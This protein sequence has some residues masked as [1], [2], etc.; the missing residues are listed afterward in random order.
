M[1]EIKQTNFWS[2]ILNDE[3]S[4]L[5]TGFWHSENMEIVGKALKQVVNNQ[6][7]N[8]CSYAVAN[9][10][11][12]L[13]QNGTDIYG[14]G[15][16]N[17][18]NHDV[19]IW[20]KTNS[21]SGNWGIA[22]NGTVAGTTFASDNPLFAVLNGVIFF[23]AGNGKVGKY[24]I[25]TNTM[26][27]TWKTGASMKG[28]TI[29]QGKIYGWIGQDIYVIDPVA[30]TLTNMKAV[31]TEQVIV[32]LVPYGSL[33]MVVCTS[34]VTLSRA[35]LWDGVST[36]S[37]VEILDVGQGLV[38]GG[39]NLGGT[40]F[41]VIGTSNKRTLKIKTYN[42][43]AFIDAYTYTARLNQA[44]TYKYIQ[45][46]SKVKAFSGYIYFIIAGTKPN[47]TYAGL[48]E[49]AIARFGREESSNPMTFEIYKT[50]DFTSARGLNGQITGNDFTIL[51]NIV[52]GSDTA[53]KA[54]A[55]VINSST[56]ETTFFLSST[57]TYSG[58]A[59]V[60]ETFKKDGA[61][62]GHDTSIEKQLT[63]VS[64]QY[65]ALPADGSV[66]VKYRKDE[67]LTWTTIFTDNTDNSISHEAA[68]I[69]ASGVNLP[70]FKEIQLRIEVTGNVKI[71]GWKIAYEPLSQNF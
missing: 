16:D 12:K 54:V 14:L 39:A 8:S 23:D 32:D 15:Q 13:I 18:T 68:N 11:T 38:S 70:T 46:A 25:A 53:E 34:T 56:N 21:L 17:N 49:Y 52:S 47:G 69:E 64:V 48:Y 67:E 4:G 65:T 28:G 29:W 40:I 61:E 9:F 71:L 26:N 57:N 27:A 6:A 58:Q 62:N 50:L 51:E 2:G 7:E 3:R 63:S 10:I 60:F 22:T 5:P 59:G 36:T 35:Y 1:S 43:G 45:P 42:G 33:L 31:N 44:G 41:V 37:W 20:K 55:A 30:D 19:T 66:T 24:T